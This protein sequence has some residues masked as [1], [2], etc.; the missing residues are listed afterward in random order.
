M[1]PIK[2]EEKEEDSAAG[3]APTDLEGSPLPQPHLVVAPRLDSSG[4]KLLP[5]GPIAVP[6]NQPPTSGHLPPC[7]GQVSHCSAEIW[8][9]RP[10]HAV[11]FFFWILTPAIPSLPVV[12]FLDETASSSPPSPPAPPR[13]HPPPQF[14]F[15]F[16]FVSVPLRISDLKPDTPSQVRSDLTELNRI[17]Y[18]SP[19]PHPQPACCESYRGLSKLTRLIVKFSGTLLGCFKITDS[20]KSAMAT[21]ILANTTDRGFPSPSSRELVYHHTL[22]PTNP[23]QPL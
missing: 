23:I 10:K 14:F 18:N 7:P 9:R 17:N 2:W 21:P 5:A 20:L 22:V 8:K 16:Q 6:S 19:R 3:S 13:R 15:F 11:F 12:F 1:R 4:V